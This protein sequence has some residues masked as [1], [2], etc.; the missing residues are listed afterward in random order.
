M[1]RT[2]EAHADGA[3]RDRALL[4]LVQRRHLDCMASAPRSSHL[5]D[6]QGF[7]CVTLRRGPAC[8]QR[9][10]Q[11]GSRFVVWRVRS[12]G[13]QVARQRLDAATGSA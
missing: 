4:T 1:A 11:V 12:G 10:E 13:S 8:P 9:G 7:W 5:L 2:L 6:L 3:R